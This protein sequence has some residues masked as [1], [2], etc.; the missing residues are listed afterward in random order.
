MPIPMSIFPVNENQSVV[1][2][3]VTVGLM[4]QQP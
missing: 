3:I 2:F 4:D 1:H